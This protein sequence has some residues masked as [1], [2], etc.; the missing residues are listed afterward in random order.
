[1]PL[2]NFHRREL[3]QKALDTWGIDNQVGMIIEQCAELI[4]AIKKWERGRASHE[5]VISELADVEIMLEQARLIFDAD[6][7]D[8]VKQGK[9]KRLQYRLESEEMW[10]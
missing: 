4:H 10:P 7:I 9:L 5:D 1:M 3:Y 8:E 6:S 2:T